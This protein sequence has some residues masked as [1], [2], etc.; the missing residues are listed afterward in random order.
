[1]PVSPQPRSIWAGSRAAG[2]GKDEVLLWSWGE[3]FL[4]LPPEHGQCFSS[5][6]VT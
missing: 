4:L 5:P 3:E 1:M 2:R 6:G